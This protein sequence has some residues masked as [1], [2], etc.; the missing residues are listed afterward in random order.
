MPYF[1]KIFCLKHFIEFEFFF[2]FF[3]TDVRTLSTQ[4]QE[5]W[6]KIMKPTNKRTSNDVTSNDDGMFDICCK[7]SLLTDILFY[8]SYVKETES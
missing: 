4:L 7:F 6:S 1:L 8:Y 2:H 3:I 5:R